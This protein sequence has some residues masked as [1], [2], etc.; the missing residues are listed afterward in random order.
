MS[1]VLPNEG[2]ENVLIAFDM[3]FAG[4]ISIN[5]YK[6]DYTPDANSVLGSFTIADF[7]GYAGHV[8]GAGAV[9]GP[10]AFNRWV[11]TWAQQ[12]WT[13][14]GAVGNSIYGYFIVNAGNKIL[15]AER[16]AAAPIDMTVNGNSIVM[17]PVFTMKSQF[18]N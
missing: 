2:K 18:S 16:F 11:L 4:T 3:T 7:S 6:N 15:L 14:N 13:K 12:T 8:L 1:L 17:T 9:A 10:D 5:L